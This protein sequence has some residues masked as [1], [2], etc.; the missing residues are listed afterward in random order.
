MNQELQAL[1]RNK[2]WEIVP[3]PSGKRLIR[4][5]WVYKIKL[6]DDG[7]VERYKARLVAKGYTQVEGVDYTECFSHVVKAMMVR[8]FLAIGTAFKWPI[9]QIDINNAFLHGHLDEEIFM[10]APEGYEVAP[11]HVCLLKHSLCGLKQAFHRWN[12]ESTG[13]LAAYG[14]QQ[15]THDHCLFFKWLDSGFIG[16]WFMLMMCSSWRLLSP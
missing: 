12:Q 5:K 6:K 1:E 14:F 16:S 13:S 3:L 15:S 2:T 11:C 7:S 9:H 4:C 10:L 8:L